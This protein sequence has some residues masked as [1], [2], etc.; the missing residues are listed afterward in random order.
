MIN[1]APK[2][3]VVCHCTD[4][5]KTSAGALSLT[6]FVERENFELL[7]GELAHFD[8]TAA[9]GNRARCYFCPN[10][11][12][13]IYHE[14]P[15]NNAV[16]RVK[17]GT[18]DNTGIIQPEMHVWTSSAQSWVSLPEDIPCHETQPSMAELLGNN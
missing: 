10:C 13:R 11:S 8:R 12:N 17:P 16:L 1:H 2:L 14:N 3:T 18:L 6:M 4:C 9:S 15:D 7:R 5:Q